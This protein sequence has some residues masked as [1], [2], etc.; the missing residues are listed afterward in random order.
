MPQS[1]K[2]DLFCKLMK[3]FVEESWVRRTNLLITRSRSK[4]MLNSFIVHVTK[5]SSVRVYLAACD[6]GLTSSEMKKGGRAHAPMHHN[7]NFSVMFL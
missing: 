5:F 1:I 4:N 7:V 3:I 2:K 6:E